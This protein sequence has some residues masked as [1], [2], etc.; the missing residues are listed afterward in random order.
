MTLA[1]T[2]GDRHAQRAAVRPTRTVCPGPSILRLAA[3]TDQEKA[4][5]T[6]VA[7]GTIGAFTEIF[8]SV[9][10]ERGDAC[11]TYDSLA[12]ECALLVPERFPHLGQHPR[13][14]FT[15]PDDLMLQSPPFT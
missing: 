11:A 15:G 4:Y 7:G 8:T 6:A 1:L 9:W 2:A 12:A 3:C 14:I 13:S 10:Q 5:E